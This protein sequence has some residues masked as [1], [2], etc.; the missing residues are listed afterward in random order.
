MKPKKIICLMPVK[1]E[2]EVLSCTLNIISQYCDYIIIAD[3]MSTDGSRELYK[4]FNNIIIIDNLRRTHS[5]QVRWDLLKKAR[6]LFGA[7]NL[8]VCLD[9]DE[10]IPP[11]LFKSFL[12]KNSFN[13]GD[14][15]RFPWIQMWKSINHFNNSGVWYKNYQRAAWVDDGK[16]SYSY[17]IIIND[18]TSRVPESFLKK[19]KK[20]DTP[21][22]HL[23]WI[24][25]KKTQYKQAWYRCT[26]LIKN[27]KS[28]KT[29]NSS[30]SHSLDSKNLKLS[31]VPKAWTED[32]NIPP[33]HT[34]NSWHEIEIYK[35][36]EKHGIIFFEP[37]DIW[38]IPKL[39]KEFIRKVGRA[40]ISI[41]ENRLFKIIRN[42]K[43]RIIK[44]IH[45]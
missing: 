34:D 44:I 16:T 13:I 29:I 23:Q 36:F 4:K 22:V 9:A 20:V 3:Q 15:F 7:G 40:P 17:E 30:Y 26:E 28:A 39:K 1:N 37:L 31:E 27:P 2:F 43:Q 24:Y 38:H 42:I 10:Y 25:W 32:C 33:C 35:L 21:I 12:D 41:P 8:I 14:S 45:Y 5:N 6:E 19:C 11:L 18:H